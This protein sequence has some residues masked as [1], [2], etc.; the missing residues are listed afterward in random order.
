MDIRFFIR[1][2][3]EATPVILLVL[4]PI[5]KCRTNKKVVQSLSPLC[6]KSSVDPA[7]HEGN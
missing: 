3:D 6:V 4:R 2:L 1:R 7:T 5:Y